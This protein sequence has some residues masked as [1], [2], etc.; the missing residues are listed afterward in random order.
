V[1]AVHC[2]GN[3]VILQF[4]LSSLSNDMFLFII[5]V[6]D[7]NYALK[8]IWIIVI[9][10]KNLVNEFSVVFLELLQRKLRAF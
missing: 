9:K 4:F 5:W 2:L 10:I 3:L 1:I 7:T 8:E 6:R